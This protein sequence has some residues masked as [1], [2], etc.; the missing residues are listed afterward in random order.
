MTSP[1][2]TGVHSRPSTVLQ[3][4]RNHFSTLS[5]SVKRLGVLETAIG[6][7]G[8]RPRVIPSAVASFVWQVVHDGVSMLP[9]LCLEF[10]SCEPLST[11]KPINDG[12]SFFACAA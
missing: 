10:Q 5:V 1:F 7:I 9:S 8:L 12:S 11:E 3:L 6:A 4:R 2:S